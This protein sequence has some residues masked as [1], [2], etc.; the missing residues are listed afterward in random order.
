[1]KT[2]VFLIFDRHGAQRM[3]KRQPSLSRA[4]IAVRIKVCI[5]DEAFR[6][7]ILIASLDVPETHVIQPVIELETAPADIGGA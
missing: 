6:S 2:T 1:M 3:A 4:E 7:P 5:P